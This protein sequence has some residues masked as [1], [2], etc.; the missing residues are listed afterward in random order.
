VVHD[1][2]LQVAPSLV[3]A[4]ADSVRFAVDTTDLQDRLRASGA[5]ASALPRGEVTFLFG[6]LEGSTEM[7]VALGDGYGP[8]LTDVRRNFREAANRF[9]GVVVDARADECFLA[10]S[11]PAAAVE[12][13]VDIQRRLREGT[14]PT[15][16]MPRLRVGLHLGTPELTADGYV[17]LDVHRA[18]RVMSAASGEQIMTSAS[19]ATAVEGQLPEGLAMLSLGWFRLKGIPEPEFLYR[20]TGPGL[21]SAVPPRATAA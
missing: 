4:I 9:G 11:V 16:M 10:F 5:D 7:L 3:K 18:A 14:W 20:I 19:V 6:D 2:A 15:G 1:A 12:A 13:A 21:T 17:G 8:L